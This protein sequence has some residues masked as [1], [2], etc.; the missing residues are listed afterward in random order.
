[1]LVSLNIHYRSANEQLRIAK[2]IE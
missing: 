2:K 1:M